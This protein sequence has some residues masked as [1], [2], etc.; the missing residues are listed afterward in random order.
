VCIGCSCRQGEGWS[1]RARGETRLGGRCGAVIG[2]PNG[3]RFRLKFGGFPRLLTFDRS[4][5]PSVSLRPWAPQ[6]PIRTPHSAAA[7][8]CPFLDDKCTRQDHRLGPFHLHVTH[9]LLVKFPVPER[10]SCSESGRVRHRPAARPFFS[11]TMR[12]FV[13]RLQRKNFHV[14]SK[15]T[16]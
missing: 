10:A 5:V 11:I 16:G 7:P 14:A 1:W 4:R 6:R 3:P 13:S 8:A 2:R 15:K 12:Q 9:A